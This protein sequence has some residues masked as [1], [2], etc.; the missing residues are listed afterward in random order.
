MINKNNF[1]FSFSGLKTA[2]LYTVK[3]NPQILKN[4]KLISQLCAEF[5]QAVIDVLIHKT[6]KA[7]Q[8]YKPKTIMLAGGVSANQELRK[9]LGGKIK[10]ELK[11]TLYMIPDTLYC[12][13]NAAM[14]AIAGHFRWQKID[15]LK[16]K[17]ALKNWAKIKTD[18]N[19]KL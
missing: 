8:K 10:K 15:S 11:N 7:A 1:D 14:I 18:A 17:N 2:V 6:L 5:Q 16:R 12:I 13:D 19:L 3:K 9:Q 4:K